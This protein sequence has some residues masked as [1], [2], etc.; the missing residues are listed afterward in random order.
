MNGKAE[1]KDL[2]HARNAKGMTGRGADEMIIMPLCVC[3]HKMLPNNSFDEWLCM[4]CGRYE[5]MS[6]EIN[7]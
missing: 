7:E 3:G 6:N 1:K 5:G 2:Y 4:F